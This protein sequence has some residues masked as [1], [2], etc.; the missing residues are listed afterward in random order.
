MPTANPTAIAAGATHSGQG[1]VSSYVRG[2]LNT[3][4]TKVR[5][6]LLGFG[7]LPP[8]LSSSDSERIVLTPGG[9]SLAV[10]A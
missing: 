7:D 10:T 5:V 4:A 2:S 8:A 1:G 6:P 9:P 3:G